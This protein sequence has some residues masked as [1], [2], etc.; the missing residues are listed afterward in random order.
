MARL[1][2][3]DEY[4]AKRNEILNAAQSL[5]FTKGY[6]QMSIQDIIAALG[7]SKGAFYHYFD[8]KPDLLDALT[9]R[10]QEQA[11]AVIEPILSDPTLSA[12]QKLQVY[13][14]S[15][16]R[17]KTARKDYLLALLR[18]YYAD[19]NSLVRQKAFTTGAQYFTPH[20][21][22]VLSQGVQ[23][24][25]FRIDDPQISAQV[26]M[27][28]FIGLGEAVAQKMLAQLDN[29]IDPHSALR[30]MSDITA[31]YNAALER[32]LGAPPNSFVLFDEDTMRAWLFDETT[33]E[34]LV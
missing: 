7:I 11:I 19:E 31:A 1:K 28:I 27:S 20:L 34:E 8:S 16:A 30:D 33:K 15:L 14:S 25:V 22:R 26:V 13:F 4:L 18:N 10:T 23:E 29:P 17:W 2:K 32:V 24:G 12:L 21:S 3:E 5:I 9:Q 6:E